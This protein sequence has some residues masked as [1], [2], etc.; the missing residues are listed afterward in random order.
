MGGRANTANQLGGQPAGEPKNFTLPDKAGYS[1]A[2]YGFLERAH[3]KNEMKQY[4]VKPAPT[5]SSNSRLGF[6]AQ[7]NKN[8]LEA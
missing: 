4:E 5:T 6:Y 1:N 2:Q 3:K 7:R 8:W